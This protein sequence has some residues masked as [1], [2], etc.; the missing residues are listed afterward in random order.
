MNKKLLMINIASTLAIMLLFIGIGIPQINGHDIKYE[1]IDWQGN[2]ATTAKS[3]FL[4]PYMGGTE[5]NKTFNVET[6]V[7]VCD[8]NVPRPQY[9]NDIQWHYIKKINVWI[10]TNNDSYVL[11]ASGSSWSAVFTTYN[12][13]IYDGEY[14]T[15]SENYPPDSY[16]FKSIET[17]SSYNYSHP[18]FQ[19]DSVNNRVYDIP[20]KYYADF[21]NGYYKVYTNAPGYSL[22]IMERSVFENFTPRPQCISTENYEVYNWSSWAR[23]GYTYLLD[24]EDGQQYHD[25][26]AICFVQSLVLTHGT[27]DYYDCH[28]LDAYAIG[29]YEKTESYTVPA[30][31]YEALTPYLIDGLL[32]SGFAILFEWSFVKKKLRKILLINFVASLIVCGLAGLLMWLGYYLPYAIGS[33]ISNFAWLTLGIIFYGLGFWGMIIITSI[34]TA[35]IFCIASTLV[36]W[37]LYRTLKRTKIWVEH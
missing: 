24:G 28:V 8:P 7:F 5:G 29:Y 14:F 36:I 23:T 27:D 31:H 11:F 34:L 10:K 13:T 3:Q 25:Y 1:T 9:K 20:D 18:I 37:L 22:L 15:H 33:S 16:N 30:I 17:Y 2:L 35:F 4:R 26:L 32:F 12:G 6:T 19:N 21:E